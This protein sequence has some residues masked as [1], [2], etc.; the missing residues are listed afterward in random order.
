MITVLDNIMQPPSAKWPVHWSLPAGHKSEPFLQRRREALQQLVFLHP[1]TY[2]ANKRDLGRAQ[3]VKMCGNRSHFTTILP[4]RTSTLTV[5]VPWEKLQTVC[6]Q[7]NEDSIT[8]WPRFFLT[9]EV[10]PSSLQSCLWRLQVSTK[11]QSRRMHKD[12]FVDSSVHSRRMCQNVESFNVQLGT[13]GD[14]FI[15]AVQSYMQNSNFDAKN[16][17]QI[18][19]VE[20]KFA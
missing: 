14:I 17:R 2:I 15:Q 7:Q 13:C 1:S 11:L 10:L 6:R 19:N 18:Y 20:R 9:H 4:L 12:V 16:S 3:H 5:T 8:S